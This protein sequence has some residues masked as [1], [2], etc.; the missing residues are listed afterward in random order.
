T[1]TTAEGTYE[2][3]GTVRSLVPLRRIV[4]DARY[5]AAR[6]VFAVECGRILARLHTVTVEDTE[7]EAPS[8]WLM[9]GTRPRTSAGCAPGPGGS[10]AQGGSVAS[11]ISKTCSPPTRTPAA[12]PSIPSRFATG[13]CW[14]TCGG[15]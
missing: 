9:S 14:A 7:L 5:G 13:R 4:R 8:N 12:T 15:R 11:A 1:A 3:E 6:Q 2:I 10:A